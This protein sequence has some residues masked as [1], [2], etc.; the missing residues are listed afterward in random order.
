MITFPLSFLN[1]GGSY[2]DAIGRLY[3]DM[4]VEGKYLEVMQAEDIVLFRLVHESR[5]QRYGYDSFRKILEYTIDISDIIRIEDLIDCGDHAS[6]E[7][8]DTDG[9][10]IGFMLDTKHDRLQVGGLLNGRLMVIDLDRDDAASL[11]RLLGAMRDDYDTFIENQREHTATYAEWIDAINN[12]DAPR[13]VRDMIEYALDDHDQF[14]DDETVTLRFSG[15][16]NLWAV[17][18]AFEVERTYTAREWADM[19]PHLAPEVAARVKLALDW[20]DPITGDLPYG[21]TD[22]MFLSAKITPADND[23]ILAAGHTVWLGK[24]A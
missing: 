22:H 20:A 18:E 21:L 13:W 24:S 12:P 8:I 6:L 7:V 5:E 16:A 23:A 1:A 17:E 11:S 10:S 9:E 4:A 3:Q 14:R 19:L 2:G 15:D